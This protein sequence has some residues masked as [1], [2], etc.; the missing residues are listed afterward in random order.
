[1]Q[2]SVK[3]PDPAHFSETGVYDLL[4]AASRGYVGIDRR[5]LKAILDRGEQ[6][7]PDLVR[8]GTEEMGEY[9]VDLEEDLVAIFRHLGTPEGIPYLV[10]RIRRQPEDVEDDIVEALIH[11]GNRVLDPLLAL[12]EEVGE[13]HGSDIAF[14]LASLGMRDER[15]LNVLQERLEYDAGDGAFLLGLYGDPASKPAL[16]KMLAEIDPDDG[17]LRREIIYAIDRVDA[18]PT[19]EKHEDEPFDI[20]EMYPEKAVPP[21]EVLTEAERLDMLASPAPEYRIEAAESFRGT[22]LSPKVQARLLELGKSDPEAAVRGAVWKSLSDATEEKPVRDAMLKVLRDDGSDLEERMGALIALA[23]GPEDTEVTRFMRQFYDRPDTRARAMEAM[24]RSLDRSFATIFPG[25][26]DDAD[27]EVRRNAIWGVGYSGLAAEVGR[28]QK[29]FDDE[30]LR[31]DA[32]F[33]YALAMPGGASRGRVRGMLRKI[34]ELAGSLTAGE[35]ELVKIALDQRLAMAGQ[36]PVFAREREQDEGDAEAWAE[37]NGAS[38][39][40]AVPPKQPATQSVG[41][42]DPCPCGS[43]K[44]HKKCCGA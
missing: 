21:V 32:L 17:D 35:A 36:E 31:A 37:S 33:A 3:F 20:W 8:F 44:K 22:T 42:N 6:A 26:L 25:H 34:D 15:V 28:L 38:G 19:A 5:W 10:D 13:E 40:V 7:V 16:E 41:R 39:P 14:V 18:E 11:L 24:W 27:V 23:Q 9:P 2:T 1:M 12:Y 30:D 29:F 4:Q 43:G